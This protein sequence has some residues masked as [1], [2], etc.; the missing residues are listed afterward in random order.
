MRDVTNGIVSFPDVIF[1]EIELEEGSNWVLII[2]TFLD[3]IHSNKNEK[4]TKYTEYFY[5]NLG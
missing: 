3:L 5:N 2:E 4:N 1:R